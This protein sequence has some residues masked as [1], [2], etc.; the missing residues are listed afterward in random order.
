M[1]SRP[2]P[3]A[4]VVVLDDARTGDDVALLADIVPASCVDG[5]GN[6]FVVFFQG[7][8]FDCL[9]C[10]NP[11]TIPQRRVGASYFATVDEVLAELR[12]AEPF[13]SGV[14]VS[15]GEATLQWRFVRRL[16]EAI[17]SDPQLARLTTLVDSNG[18]AELE[19]WDQLAPWMDGAMVDLKAFDPDLHLWLTRRSNEQVLRS[20][21]HLAE[22][23]KLH[24]VRLLLIPGVNDTPE[25]LVAFATWLAGIDPSVRV[26]LNGFRT[27][28][29]RLLACAFA[30]ATP[31]HLTA[32]TELLAG[33][34]LHA[35]AISCWS[36]GEAG[37]ADEAPR[38]AV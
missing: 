19:V 38:I 13:V 31:A 37:A 14:T 34:G 8:N 16:F 32:A 25:E 4:D 20:I 18:N 26:R 33:H 30:E 1:S 7:C 24:E 17:K 9:A 27:A 21:R 23:G 11:H 5:P 6:R 29:T 36:P 15:G 28:G 12:Q 10:H 22:L 2:A 3:L 35:D